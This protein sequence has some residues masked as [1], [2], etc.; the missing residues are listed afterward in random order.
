MNIKKIPQ[1][2]VQREIRKD[3]SPLST[4]VNDIRKADLPAL[5]IFLETETSNNSKI[6]LLIVPH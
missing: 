5:K 6:S 1:N 2:A 3:R 4:F